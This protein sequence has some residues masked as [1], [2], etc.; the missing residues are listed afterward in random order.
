VAGAGA[1]LKPAKQR[2]APAQGRAAAPESCSKVLFKKARP[3]A[4]LELAAHGAGDQGAHQGEANKYGGKAENGD[5]GPDGA[6]A[7]AP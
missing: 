7:Q 4:A 5:A 1:P 6:H 2:T 3:A